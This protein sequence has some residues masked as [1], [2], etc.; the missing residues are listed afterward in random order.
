MN[1]RQL[2]GSILSAAA[3]RTLD[4]AGDALRFAH[5]Q[6]NIT[7]EPGPG[8]FDLARRIPGLKGVELQM[9][10][11]NTTLWDS[12]TLLAYKRGA[13]KAGLAVSSLAGVWTPG[14]SVLQP[15]QAVDVLHKAI[16]AAGALKA[17]VILVTAFEKNAPDM[18]RESSWGPTVKLLQKVAAAASDAGVTLAM[19]TSLTPAH[20]KKWIDLVGRPSIKVYYDADNVERYGHKGA[21]VPGYGVLGKSRIAQIHLKNEE[22]LLEEPGRV[23]WTEALKAI[24]RIGYDGWLCFES[25]HSGPEQCIESTQKNMAFVRRQLAQA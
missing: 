15:D 16:R 12:E 8:V 25:N 19:E 10:F 5:R 22:S 20:D 9:H 24:R 3:A 1:R 4:A 11:R 6:A 23:N 2:V 17:G 13:E 7:K 18:E 14:V 21:A